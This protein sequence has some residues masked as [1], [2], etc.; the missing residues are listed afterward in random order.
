MVKPRHEEPVEAKLETF[1]NTT[2]TAALHKIDVSDAANGGSFV[3]F[4]G[5][6]TAGIEQLKDI[7]G[8]SLPESKVVG[9]TTVDGSPII[10]L[11]ANKGAQEVI[12][13]WQEKTG[14]VLKY[15]KPIVKKK[16]LD[17]IKVRGTVGNIGQ[18]GTFLSGF[19]DSDAKN[20]LQSKNAHGNAMLKTNIGDTS[21]S[22]NGKTVTLDTPVTQKDL[23]K[24][25]K[26]ANAKYTFQTADG[27]AKIVSAGLSFIGNGINSHYGTQKKE[28]NTR[29]THAKGKINEI[30]SFSQNPLPDKD[31]RI[32]K[33]SNRYS[34]MQQNSFIVSNAIKF[35]G[36]LG[37]IM[38]GNKQLKA[39]GYL[40]LA[41]KVVTLTGKDEDPHKLEEDQTMVTRVRRR[42]NAIA[43]IMEWVANI[44]LWSS[45]LWEAD[46]DKEVK[47]YEPTGDKLKDALNGAAKY[48][49]ALIRPLFDIDKT[50]FRGKDNIQWFQLF[51]ALAVFGSL[52]AKSMAPFADKRID[53]NELTTHATLALAQSVADGKHGEELTRLTTQMVQNRELGELEGDFSKLYTDIANRLEHYHGIRVETKDTQIAP[54]EEKEAIIE[55]VAESPLPEAAELAYW[56]SFKYRNLA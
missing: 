28:D 39:S 53:T 22:L 54:A 11:R 38:A 47:A 36:K 41:A 45:S 50:K 19:F 27:G 9:S 30:L 52:T 31:K 16:K 46:K 33:E 56:R 44:T 49:K 32:T 23:D 42:S 5:H 20:Q 48:G 25:Q 4:H 7:I 6:K 3:F 21:F 40:S 18:M 37:L 2:K 1:V 17:L 15:Q 8:Y 43:G 29:L 24:A 14:E 51:G 26:N 10:I 12:D 55:Q 34:F 35:F 13:Q